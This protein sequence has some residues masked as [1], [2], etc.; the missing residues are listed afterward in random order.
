MSPRRRTRDTG[1]AALWVALAALSSIAHAQAPP[2]PETPWPI[3]ASA[4][5]RALTESS[6][7]TPVPRQRYDLPA[8]ID[9]AERSNPDTRAAWEAARAAAA[10]VGLVESSYLP[11]LSL[12]AI[13]GF[14]RT[15][16]PLPK[17]LVPQGYFVSNTREVIPTLA[18]KWLLF[19]FGQRDAK[20]EAARAD[21][22]VANV[23]FTGTHQKII[24]S[25]S[26]AYYE[27]GAAH[28][29]LRAAQ[30]ALRAALVSQDAATTQRAQGLAT[31]V[32]VAQAERQTAQARYAL[33]QA[34]GNLT[35][36]HANLI[37]S[38]G[39]PPDTELEV[40]DS[41][42]IEM[43]A[44]PSESV[45]AAIR[46]AMTRRPDIIAALGAV[47]AAEAK[48]KAERRSYY[49]TIALGARVFQNIGSL[50]SDGEPYS[51]IDKTG[52]G[53]LLSFSV[54]IFDGGERSSR[55]SAAQANMRALEAQLNATRDAAATQVVQ[56]YN[57]LITS[58]AQYD[59][60]CAVSEA[61]HTAYE[62]A[63]RSYKAG[64]GT[65]TDLATEE[66]AV[67]QAENQVEDARAASHT[68]AARL[69][70]AIGS[71]TPQ[72]RDTSQ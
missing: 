46:E 64:V 22:F 32:A 71:I 14:Q 59:A 41:S 27:L 57:T 65:Y 55:V 67:A 23:A 43:P 29:R 53:V 35:I 39:I 24:F 66:N 3:P 42:E 62:A 72:A 19:D 26:Q 63:L 56:A 9:L 31:V 1:A 33:A 70:F 37:A 18:L 58:L 8:L 60:A 7:R 11:Q 40:A 4:G 2:R 25:V 28:G 44:R 38:L 61:A 20:R 30:A 69:A 49:P 68:A 48:L 17:N 21:S 51:N 13:G 6:V 16:L 52:A 15:P 47:D 5:E 10:A 34:E 36:A 45:S 50:N 54:P 12:E